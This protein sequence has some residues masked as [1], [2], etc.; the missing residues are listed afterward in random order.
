MAETET[1]VY[2]SQDGN[3]RIDVTFDG[4]T[5]WLTHDQI[6]EL[7]G[8]DAPII[9]KNIANIIDEEIVNPDVAVSRM[10]VVQQRG[11]RK[12]SCITAVVDLDMALAVGSLVNPEQAVAFRQWATSLA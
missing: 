10:E 6:A 1:V 12:I 11:S 8:V 9:K 3:T 5:V 7:Y 4:H 2:E